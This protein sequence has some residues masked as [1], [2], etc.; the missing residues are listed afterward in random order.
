VE[1]LALEVL[2]VLVLVYMLDGMMVDGV[3]L[4]DWL[5]V[6]LQVWLVLQLAVS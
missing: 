1:V 2:S 3:V 4:E 6:L 5:L